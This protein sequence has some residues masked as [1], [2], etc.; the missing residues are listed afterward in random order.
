MNSF[1]IG[2]IGVLVEYGGPE[3]AEGFLHDFE[4]WIVFMGCVGILVIEMAVLA[5]IGKDK[6]SLSD[7]FAIDLPDPVSIEI[8][9]K[10]RQLKPLSWGVPVLLTGIMALSLYLQERENYIPERRVFAEF[11]I[12]ISEWKGKTG[13]VEDNIL[14]SLAAE[15]YLMSDYANP[16]NAMVNLW[17]AYYGDQAAGS[18]AHSPRSCI[19]GGGWLIKD[20]TIRNINSIQI[21]GRPLRVN[22]LLIKKGEYTQLVYYWFKQRERNITNEWLLKWF[23]FWDAMTR[24]RTDG[25]LVRLTAL[26]QPG[27]DLEDADA[28]LVE[29]ATTV[30]PYL[31]EYIPD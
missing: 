21:N 11:P 17:I 19:P 12:N 2:V 5:K 27:E 3:Q 16:E 24:N 15:D 26:V 1:R 22:R 25:A 7:A 30:V 28:R 18:T 20:L 8:Q 6:N 29:F 13:T 10:P 23:L 14:E 9:R 4:G 31:D